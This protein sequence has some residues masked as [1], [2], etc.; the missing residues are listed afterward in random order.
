MER[1]ALTFGSLF[2]G[3]GGIDLGFERAGMVCKWQVELNPFCREVLHK[4]WPR[5][6]RWDD[7]CTFPPPAW[8]QCECCDNFLCTWHG[9]HA[10]DCDE[11]EC[12]ELEV[13]DEL[14]LNP[15]EDPHPLWH[16]DVICGGD[17]CQANSA[18]VG[19]NSS[20]YESLGGEFVRIIDAL[21]PR[22]VVR[23][24]PTFARKDAP[25]PWWRMRSELESIG[26][27][28]LPFR[29]RACCFGADHQRDRMF[30]LGELADANSIRLQGREEETQGWRPSESTRRIHSA[31][32]FPVYA[33]RGIRSRAG[34]PDYVERVKALGN[35]VVPQVSQW[36][37]E[38]LMEATT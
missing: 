1:K 21:R 7:A 5:V 14:G 11:E 31:D 9:G 17:P 30:L 15:Y 37:G 23:E 34:V 36:I 27:A 4:H 28:V 29:L 19:G 20:E 18:A 26:Y 3:A 22:I 25:W 16:V 24:N 32:W 13:W 38:R 33:P 6:P 2:S 12:P 35:A 10:H 8:I